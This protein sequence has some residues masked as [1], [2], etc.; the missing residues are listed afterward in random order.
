MS[1]RR[2]SM[3]LVPSGTVEGP[4]IVQEAQY[5]RLVDHEVRRF[6]SAP[7]TRSESAAARNGSAA[8]RCGCSPIR[9][10]MSTRAVEEPWHQISTE[11][12]NR[13]HGA[14]MR[15][16]N[17]PNRYRATPS[18]APVSPLLTPP[19]AGSNGLFLLLPAQMPENGFSE[20]LHQATFGPSRAL[21][22][23]QRHGGA[24]PATDSPRHDG[25]HPP[26]RPQ[27]I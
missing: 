1:A 18:T 16:A 24:A 9:T 21:T 25:P 4:A 3:E 22:D 19:T 6:S 15:V 10:T 20:C 2:T 26:H 13:I 17:R 14:K 12:D 27:E 8:V 23:S 11:T 5:H 7:T